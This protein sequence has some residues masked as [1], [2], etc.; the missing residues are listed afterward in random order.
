MLK[1]KLVGKAP[2][3][4]SA[5]DFDNNSFDAFSKF[6]NSLDAYI[7]P[8]MVL[9]MFDEFEA[10]DQKIA[11]GFFSGEILG[12][13]RHQMQ[14]NPSV[15]FILAGSRLMEGTSK[16]YI[17]LISTFTLQE[18]VS[19]LGKQDARDL[20]C[21]PLKDKVFF[22]EAAVD[23]LVNVTNGHPLLLQTFCH[24]L[25]HQMKLQN[26]MNFISVEDAVKVINEKAH[27]RTLC[28][29]IMNELDKI[30]ED[31]LTEIANR[32]EEGQQWVP[33][34]RVRAQVQHFHSA[35]EIADGL[36]HLIM[37]RLIERISSPAGESGYRVTI[38]FL[39]R[40]IYYLS[41]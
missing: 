5:A 29:F 25:I 26:H 1:H 14:Y 19:Y 6:M 32:N 10:I 31:L 28:Y 3:V 41:H 38:P 30:E 20:V 22:E 17:G 37:R 21:V 11:N 27:S 2:D 40:W 23:E 36:Q 24:E 18:E 4:P 12:L 33:E 9:L 13:L 8:G 15:G 16:E 34:S 7:N 35:E 39:S